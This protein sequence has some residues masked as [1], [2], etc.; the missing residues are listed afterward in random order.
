[1]DIFNYREVNR[2]PM[3]FKTG[4]FSYLSFYLFLSIENVY[5]TSLNYQSIKIL[6]Y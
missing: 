2:T 6:I 5:F 3:F 1:M 4:N